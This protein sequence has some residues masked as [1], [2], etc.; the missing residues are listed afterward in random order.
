MIKTIT[1]RDGRSVP[2]N[3]EKIANAIFR[4][5]Q[6]AGGSDYDEALRLAYQV[7]DYVENVLGTTSPTVEQVQ[8]AVEKILIEDGHSRTAK[9]Y[10]LYRAERTRVRDMNTRLMKTYEDLTFK[11]AEEVDLKQIGRAHV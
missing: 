5:A 1:K 4:A 11:S 8:D 7:C 9:G 10:I 2:F 3:H 6:A